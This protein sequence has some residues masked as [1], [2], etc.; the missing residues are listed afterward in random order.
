MSLPQLFT[1]DLIHVGQFAPNLISSPTSPIVSQSQ[2]CLKSIHGHIDRRTDGKPQDIM[3][4]A[5]FG[6]GEIKSIECW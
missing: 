5:P 6:G 3:P 4:P 1:F 2:V